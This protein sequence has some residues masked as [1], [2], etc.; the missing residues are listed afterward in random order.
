MTKT[1]E[2][3]TEE[4]TKHVDIKGI[5]E[6]IAKGLKQA[7]GSGDFNL[8]IEKKVSTIIFYHA[9]KEREL[10]LLEHLGLITREKP[11]YGKC[12]LTKKAYEL[13][14]QLKAEGYYD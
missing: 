12:C 8:P 6:E 4:V 7:F 5:T 3:L 9:V 10:E 13:Y 14:E 11:D 2:T 1:I